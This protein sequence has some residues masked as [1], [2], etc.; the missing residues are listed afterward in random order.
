MDAKLILWVLFVVANALSF[1]YKKGGSIK[2]RKGLN[3][4][5]P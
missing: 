5:L 1:S 2:K 3:L 4:M